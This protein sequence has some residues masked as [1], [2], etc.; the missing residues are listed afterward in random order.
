LDRDT[1]EVI[2]KYDLEI[3]ATRAPTIVTESVMI[4]DK[5][6]T[7]LSYKV[8]LYNKNKLIGLFG[9]GVCINNYIALAQQPTLK[10]PEENSEDL[11][12]NE[13][14]VKSNINNCSVSKRE[15]ECLHYLICGLSAKSIARKLNLS[16]RTIEYYIGKMKEKF[17]CTNTIEL[18]IKALSTKGNS[19]AN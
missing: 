17:D 18:I 9:T 6:A 13:F 15:K 14:T 3:R 11:T 8:P 12:Q 19:N 2:R 5:P 1:I 10:N 7:F 4:N 16:P